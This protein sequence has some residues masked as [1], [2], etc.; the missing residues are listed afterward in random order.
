[1]HKT[2]TKLFI[3]GFLLIFFAF[4]CLSIYLL[5]K[6]NA[7]IAIGKGHYLAIDPSTNISYNME[8]YEDHS[9]K[10]FQDQ[11]YLEGNLEHEQAQYT[12][13]YYIQTKDRK[14]FMSVN[15]DTVSVPIEINGNLV[16]LVF[17]Y[18]GN[19]PMEQ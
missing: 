8:I 9:V 15:R 11:V 7:T 19:T 12:D 6:L 1:M 10:I 14:C 18:G 5:V 17:K 3:S 16:S 2:S 13:A 4:V